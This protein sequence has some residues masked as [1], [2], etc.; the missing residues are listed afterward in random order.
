MKINQVYGIMAAL[1]VACLAGC[2]SPAA[3]VVGALGKTALQAAGLGSS[4]PQPRPIHLDI[5][6]GD[7]VNSDRA[8]H[9]FAVVMRTYALKSN[10]GFD[11]AQRAALENDTPAAIKAD[12]L[13]VKEQVLAPGQHY[14]IDQTLPP[15]TQFL[16]V[17]VMFQSPQPARWRVSI[18]MDAMADTLRMGVHRCSFTVTDGLKDKDLQK[19]L[20]LAGSASCS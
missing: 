5:F 14:R 12:V 13:D 2:A 19:T 18:P 9:P 15:G 3:A 17:A 11:Q 16:G 1:C 6:A 7:G 20:A 4:E 10:S 8:G